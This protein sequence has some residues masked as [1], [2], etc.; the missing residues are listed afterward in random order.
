MATSK[1]TTRE[2]AET[3]SKDVPLEAVLA[4]IDRQD[5]EIRRL[6]S[7]LVEA[8]DNLREAV[9][10]CHE[11]LDLAR[12]KGSKPRKAAPKHPQAK[13]TSLNAARRRARAAEATT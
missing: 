9:S 1:Q 12:P 6:R 2:L 4:R 8:N 11:L 3:L 5:E 7:E 13:V 10:L